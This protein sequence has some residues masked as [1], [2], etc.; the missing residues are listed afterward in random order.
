[1]ANL[2]A[3]AACSFLERRLQSRID[4]EE[5][6]K[7]LL[8][9]EL[10]DDASDAEDVD[11]SSLQDVE[12]DSAEK[13]P[14]PQHINCHVL[15]PAQED[16]DGVTSE[17]GVLQ[18][19]EEDGP[20]AITAPEPAYQQL[21][22]LGLVLEHQGARKEVL[23]LLFFTV[24]RGQGAAPALAAAQ[25]M[26]YYEQLPETG[27]P[28]SDTDSDTDHDPGP[29][30]DAGPDPNPDPTPDLDLDPDPAEALWVPS[31]ADMLEALVALGYRDPSLTTRTSP[32]QAAAATH[33]RTQ[34]P[35][36]RHPQAAAVPEHPC[37]ASSPRAS[38]R[39]SQRGS[40]ATAVGNDLSS[41]SQQPQLPASSGQRAA[42]LLPCEESGSGA[43]SD[44]Q[45]LLGAGPAGAQLSACQLQRL[46]QLLGCLARLCGVHCRRRLLSLAGAEAVGGKGAEGQ[47][48]VAA[49]SLLNAL[50]L[51]LSSPVG[52]GPLLLE[53]SQALSAL[54]AAWGAEGRAAAGR[55]PEGVAWR[56][57][58]AAAA[59]TVSRA[60][61][62]YQAGLRII[63]ALPPTSPQLVQLKQECALSLLQQLCRQVRATPASL[64][65]MLFI[66]T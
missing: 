28:D 26:T 43:S 51:L 44:A 31:P 49:G 56:A 36:T 14:P 20:D 59:V 32:G 1:M 37:P 42:L 29:D 66:S 38:L 30:P 12:K 35:C 7:V 24:W 46:Q 63:Q 3:P 34:A 23:K 41:A 33:T 47:G 8:E 45:A 55:D 18:W 50:L 40:V 4:R 13:D 5:K 16:H 53:L 25:L 6:K 61:P 21:L 2:Q 48:T 65:V 17:L 19:H 22:Q 58:A 54:V 10:S 27:G 11:L 52:G 15:Q 57:A 64:H 9:A 62:S 39:R 60:G